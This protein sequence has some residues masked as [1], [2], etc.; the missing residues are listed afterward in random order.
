MGKIYSSGFYGDG[1][2]FILLCPPTSSPLPKPATY[3]Q[4]ILTSDT[5]LYIQSINQGRNLEGIPDFSLCFA[6]T[7]NQI[8]LTTSK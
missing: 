2:I 8:L 3:S 7:S 1:I 5:T 4:T 6:F